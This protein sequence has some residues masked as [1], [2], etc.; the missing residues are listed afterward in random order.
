MGRPGP[1][2]AALKPYTR[3]ILVKAGT[4]IVQSTAR[5]WGAILRSTTAFTP[6]RAPVGQRRN[7]VEVEFLDTRSGEGLSLTGARGPW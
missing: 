7:A 3:P 4:P 5:R 2:G 6:R 1:G